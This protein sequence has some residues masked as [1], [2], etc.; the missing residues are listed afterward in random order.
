[1]LGLAGEDAYLDLEL[2]SVPK[3]CIRMSGSKVA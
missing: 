1:M 2:L 3:G